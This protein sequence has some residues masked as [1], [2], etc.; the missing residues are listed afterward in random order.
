ME[1]STL[2]GALRWLSGPGAGLA[3]FALIEWLAHRWPWLAERTASEMR[4]LSLSGTALLATLG[5]VLL[6]SATGQAFPV[7]FWMWAEMLYPVI[8][9]ACTTATAAHGVWVLKG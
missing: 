4:T 6:L 9:A 1:P 2:S 5:H 3:A 8:F 7:G